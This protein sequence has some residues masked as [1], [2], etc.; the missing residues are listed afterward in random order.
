M[1]IQNKKLKVYYAHFMGLYDTL[2]EQRD[3]RTLEGMGFDVVNPNNAEVSLNFTSSLDF[4]TPVYTYEEVFDM[5]FGQMVRDCDIL[6]YRALPDGK[7]SGGVILE[8]KE[9]QK[10]EK[11]VICLPNRTEI[12]TKAMS[13]PETRAYLMDI[14]KR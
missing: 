9:A 2:Q 5:V 13:G 14:G 4:L 1:S 7:I 11:P 10:N 8:I 12:L 6:A 3:I